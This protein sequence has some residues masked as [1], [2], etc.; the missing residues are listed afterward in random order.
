VPTA[1]AWTLEP[2]TSYTNTEVKL[3]F[4]VA[5]SPVVSLNQLLPFQKYARGPLQTVAE[6][7]PPTMKP[8]DELIS[9]IGTE[10]G[11]PKLTEFSLHGV[12]IDWLFQEK[13]SQ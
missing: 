12:P 4:A 3:P 6:L 8:A 10:R 2:E 7:L 1:K 9:F 5:N 11:D 13:P